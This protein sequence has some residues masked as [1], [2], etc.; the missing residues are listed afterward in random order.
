MHDADCEAVSIV[1]IS[2]TFG[3]IL[4]LVLLAVYSIV[5]IVIEWQTSQLYVR[6]FFT[7]IKGDV[8]FYAVNTT[9]SLFL[10]W[11]T[12]LL[13]GVCLLCLNQERHFQHSSSPTQKNN[14][15]QFPIGSLKFWKLS[16]V[17]EPEVKRCQA[18]WF[19]LSQVIMFA[20]LGFDERFLIH[21]TIG[22]WL[23]RN[24]AYLL[25]GLGLVEVGLLVLLGNLREKPKTARYFLYSAAVLFAMMV[26]IDAKFPSQMVLRLS[27]EELT[28]LWADVCLVL[29]AWE[30]LRQHIHRLS[31]NSSQVVPIN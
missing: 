8:F 5:L 15:C 14:R 27:L 9:F 16:S 30:I 22:L 19:Y 18:Y 25:L 13:F 17:A 24:D 23:G 3:L 11:A 6:Q 2:R 31:A 20:Y 1:T 4:G 29:F 28:K 10:L 12:A 21:E 26:V 7:D